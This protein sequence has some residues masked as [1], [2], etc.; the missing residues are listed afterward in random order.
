MVA[1]KG[2]HDNALLADRAAAGVRTYIP[3]RKQKSHRWDDKPAEFEEAFRA[4]R[5][6]EG[7]RG[8]ELSR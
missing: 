8:R 3:E 1:D 5:R 2:Y 4:N 7:D 6:V